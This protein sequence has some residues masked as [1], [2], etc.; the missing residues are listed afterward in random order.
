MILQTSIRQKLIEESLRFFC[1]RQVFWLLD[2]PLL[3]LPECSYR[4]LSGFARF[5]PS[6]SGGTAAGFHGLPFT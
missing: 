1:V 3:A 2:L 6:Y 5:V 4:I